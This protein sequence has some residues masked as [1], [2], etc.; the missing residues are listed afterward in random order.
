MVPCQFASTRWPA[1]FGDIKAALN[2]SCKWTHGL[3]I[4]A[5]VLSCQSP[6][7]QQGGNIIANGLCG[8]LLIQTGDVLG[9]GTTTRYH[10]AISALQRAFKF[11]KWKKLHTV[12]PSLRELR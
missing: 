7:V 1:T 12:P 4:D 5:I 11:G 10:E 2:Q 6:E 3:E 9:G 8:I